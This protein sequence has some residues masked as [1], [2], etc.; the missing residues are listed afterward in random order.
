MLATYL[1]CLGYSSTMAVMTPSMV[2][3]CESSPR[4]INMKKKRQL[5]KGESGI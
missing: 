1:R 3:N 2:Q 5:H 4:N